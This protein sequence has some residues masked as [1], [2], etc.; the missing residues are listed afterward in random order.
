MV[1]DGVV[2]TSDSNPIL[3]F[4]FYDN[5]PQACEAYF[6]LEREYDLSAIAS[7]VDR[8]VRILFRNNDKSFLF[9]L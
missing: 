8:N 7:L 3:E 5:N 6:T 9:E 2:K 1:T 4:D